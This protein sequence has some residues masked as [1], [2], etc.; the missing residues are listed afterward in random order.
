M[1]LELAAERRQL[2]SEAADVAGVAGLSGLNGES[3]NCAC[4]VGAEGQDDQR[5]H[6]GQSEFPA[7]K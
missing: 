2:G 6:R 5:C 1:Q 3:R 7:P 4:R